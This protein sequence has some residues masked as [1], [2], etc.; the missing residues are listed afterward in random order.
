LG[1]QREWSGD[2][3]RRSDSFDVPSASFLLKVYHDFGGTVSKGIVYGTSR[4]P[5]LGYEPSSEPPALLFRKRMEYGIVDRLFPS[6]NNNER[7]MYWIVPL[8]IR[9]IVI[10]L[11]CDYDLFS[12]ASQRCEQKENLPTKQFERDIIMQAKSSRVLAL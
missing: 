3:S 6:I 8:T 7:A 12:C 1:F 2:R 5:E 10:G 4:E 9:T 11:R